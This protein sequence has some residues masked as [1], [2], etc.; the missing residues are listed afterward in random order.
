MQNINK[1]QSFFVLLAYALPS[2]MIGV[3]VLI[4]G[5]ALE[6]ISISLHVPLTSLQWLLSGYSIGIAVFFMPSGKLCD[7]Y[8][9]G[10]VQKIGIIL[11][12]L[13]SLLIS[14]SFNFS[15]ITIGRIF[16]GISSAI[17]ISSTLTLIISNYPAS[18]RGIPLSA[19]SSASGIGMALGPI[20]GGFLIHY[21]NWRSIF[22]LNI[23]ICF[24]ALYLIHN[25]IYKGAIKNIRKRSSLKVSRYT[26]FDN[27]LLKNKGFI[28]ACFFAFIA[29][30]CLLS[31]LFIVGIY[32]QRSYGL[33]PL[34]AGIALLPFSISYFITSV[35][36]GKIKGNYNFKKIISIGF[37]FSAIGLFV[38]TFI[39]EKQ[40]Y[41][42]LLPGF[43]LFSI[44]FVT[45]N[46]SSMKFALNSIEPQQAG[47]ASGN[48]MMLRWL[49]GAIGVFTMSKVFSWES[50]N[51]SA[52]NYVQGLHVTML[53][54]FAIC[55]FGL[56]LNL[57]FNYS[58]VKRLT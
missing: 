32:L 53:Y 37:I 56:I 5:V 43:I 11:F 46:L 40:N 23:V 54:L 49:G 3:D 57:L 28:I 33:T 8:G 42:I 38:F 34:F 7:L 22:L 27:Q 52:V 18:G 1:Y 26:L 30:F 21:L 17:I 47:I 16:Q 39:T 6:P 2:F 31:W 10:L 24:L 41:F 13:S 19:M 50:E 29:Y 58:S 15:L 36:I 25:F 48:A 12:M 20:I 9:A 55:C 35:F 51:G 14:L 44:G 4:I 45:I